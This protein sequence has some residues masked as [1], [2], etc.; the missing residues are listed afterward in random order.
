M[1]A[2]AG[3]VDAKVLAEVALTRA[4][5]DR[6]VELMGRELTPVELGIFGAMWSEH[7]GYKT[8]KPLLKRFP[9][10]GPLVLQGPGE[11]AGAIDVGEGWA[12]V[13]KIES[14]NHPSA[15]EP[16]A[17]AATGVGGILRDIFTM[18]AFP[19]ATLDSLRFGPPDE[20]RNRWLMGGVIAG[21]GDYGNCFGVPTVGG[22]IYFEDCYTDNP[23]VNAMAVGLIRKERLMRATAEG[24]GNLVMLVGADTGRDGIHGATFASVELDAASEERRPAVQVG[25]PFLEKLLME[26]C[27]ELIDQELVVG[28][29][30]LGA[31][32]LTSSAVEVGHKGGSGIDLDV[33]EVARREQ[34]MGAYEVMLSES[35]ERM[36]IIVE[37]ERQAAVNRVFR[38]YDLH[39]DVIGE[40]NGSGRLTVRDGDRVEAD[41]PLTLLVDQVPFR[42]PTGAPSPGRLA[43]RAQALPAPTL[44]PPEALRRLIG[45]PNLRSRRAVW[46]TYDHMV[47]NNTVIRP[48]GDAAV[49]RIKGTRRAIAVCTDGNGRYCWLD[50]RAGAAIAV[51]E[52]ARNVVA[53]GAR[54]AAITDCLN[55]GNPEKPEVFWELS[56][57][58]DGMAEACRALSVPVVSGNVSLYNDTSGSSIYPSPVV[59]M[60]GVMEDVGK[61][62]TAGFK[63][64]GDMVLLIGE[65]GDE[66]GGSEYAK[67]C[68][69]VVAG[70]PPRLDL[71]LERR[72]H[73]AVLAAADEELLRS[74]HD[75]SDG[76]LAIAIAESAM[77]GGI[78]AS[79]RGISGDRLS[80]EALLFAESQ[81]R[82]LV[83]CEAKNVPALRNVCK[84]FGVASQ[85]LG[86]VGGD[87]VEIGPQVAEPLAELMAIWERWID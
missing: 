21:I 84:R 65:T 67:T 38:K 87:R 3:V 55:F 2:G 6:A 70:A 45:S 24:Q 37:P 44:T 71:D 82:F 20:A 10:S 53:T 56:E 73:E 86:T 29:Q 49:L 27:L 31:A 26:A 19:I 13:F 9:T 1:T 8:S 50:P 62:L 30:D 83:S 77:I 41:I 23:L 60:V 57:A 39:A 51:A 7:C 43:L 12:V 22:E 32:G 42:H 79:C 75:L 14:H 59:G 80:T 76:G 61:R 46:R 64:G 69:G 58:V 48:G 17:G 72:T 5:Y 47:Q 11:N 15:I 18:G 74:C 85:V 28:M 54:P 25:N 34:G 40:V 63:T 35:Q 68:L 78:G 4:E 36:L 66:L 33:S 52:A 81:S 16:H